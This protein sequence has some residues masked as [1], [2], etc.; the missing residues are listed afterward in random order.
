MAALR[1]FLKK[2]SLTCNELMMARRLVSTEPIIESSS[3]AQRLRDLPKDLPG[4]QIKREVSQLIGRTPLVFLNKVTEGCGAYIAV[5]QEMMQPTASIK[6]RPAMAMIADAEKKNL[7]AP[8]K[9]TLIEPT[10][11]NMGISMAFM[12][13]MKGYKMV[14]TMPSYTSLERRVTMRAFGADLILT[15]P[16]KGMGGTVK[17]AYELLESTPNAFMLQQFS[18]PANTQVHFETTGPEIW[19]DTLGK[20]DIFVMGIGSG[21]TV[22]GVGQYLKSQNPNVKIYGVEPAESNVLNGGKPGPHHITGNGV[23][24]KPDIL[25]MDVMEKV[26]EVSSEDAVNMARELALKEG[27]M[28]GIS[29]GANTVA[30]LKLARLPENKGKLIVTVH[31]SFGERY[32]SSVLFQELRKEAENM[33]PVAVD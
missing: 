28:V 22:S 14:L 16:T 19:E 6:D 1:S 25:D 23:G 4:T 8:G 9:T 30:A 3:F 17:K 31:P 29:S 15:D 13:T 11:G 27:L 33:Q 12:A 18:N 10:S 20:V 7:I 21:G 32:L 2:R 26:L 24:F 5:K